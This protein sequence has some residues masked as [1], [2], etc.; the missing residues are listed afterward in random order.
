MLKSSY[1]DRPLGAAEDPPFISDDGKPKT[2]AAAN[3]QRNRCIKCCGYYTAAVLLILATIAVIL[4]VT[5]FVLGG[6]IIRVGNITVGSLHK[7][8][9]RSN[10][11][12]NAEVLV[13]NPN[14][15]SIDYGNM[16][17][18]LFYRGVVVGQSRAPPG[19]ARARRTVTINA[20]VDIMTDR[21]LSQP[22][23]DADMLSGVVNVSSY[24]RVGG[25]INLGI[26]EKQMTMKMSCNV[27]INVT[28]KAIQHHKCRRKI[29]L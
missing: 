24:T 6:P 29:I 8:L 26:F 4:A 11:T 20:A 14:F 21:V 23:L 18:T 5:V 10:V 28:S 15:A 7:L 13:R 25:K 3:I 1:Q 9:S 19:T 27:S 12:L 2:A 17:T 22:D 16:T